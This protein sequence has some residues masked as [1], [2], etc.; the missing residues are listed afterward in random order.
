MEESWNHTNLMHHKKLYQRS[1]CTVNL[2]KVGKKRLKRQQYKNLYGKPSKSREKA[3][4]T[5]TI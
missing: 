3:I 4:K 5:T 2:V 1:I